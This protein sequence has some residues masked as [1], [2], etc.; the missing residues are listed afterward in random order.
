[1]NEPYYVYIFFRKIENS[2]KLYC[3]FYSNNNVFEKIW[4][5]IYIISKIGFFLGIRVFLCTK[6]IFEPH[7]SASIRKKNVTKSA[8]SMNLMQSGK[9]FMIICD[10]NFDCVN[11]R[12]V[13][14]FVSNCIYNNNRW[15]FSKSWELMQ[16][17]GCVL[18]TLKF[19]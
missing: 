5:I 10:Q 18:K 17:D 8:Y 14:R 9:I 11:V 19:R 16:N 1:M 15:I 2:S 13:Y 7:Y 3:R 4:I 6:H 12:N